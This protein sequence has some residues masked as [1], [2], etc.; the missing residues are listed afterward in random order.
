LL[1]RKKEYDE[2]LAQYSR[3]RSENENE[4]K[5]QREINQAIGRLQQEL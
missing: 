1:F 4:E 5:A 2:L 3:K